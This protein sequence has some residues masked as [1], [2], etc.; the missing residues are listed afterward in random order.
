M[1]LKRAV[2]FAIHCNTPGS[3]PK[4]L[5]LPAASQS[6]A[7]D[8][9]LPSR[10]KR[11]WYSGDI[12]VDQPPAK[13]QR[14]S[15]VHQLE[16]FGAANHSIS[17]THLANGTRGKIARPEPGSI[18][19]KDTTLPLATALA[20]ASFEEAEATLKEC[21]DARTFWSMPDL[22]VELTKEMLSM[23]RTPG[24]YSLYYCFIRTGNSLHARVSQAFACVVLYKLCCESYSCSS[25]VGKLQQANVKVPRKKIAPKSKHA[26]RRRYSL[27]S[28]VK[29]C[30]T[31]GKIYCKL[32]NEFGGYGIV[33]LLP[34][35]DD[36]M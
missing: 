22:N 19:C 23:S 12:Q 30:M 28:Y 14:P 11:Q 36:A 3:D 16:A 5:E 15:S 17:N 31:L 27:Y 10:K 33:C 2:P 21:E 18:L 35:I 34:V 32:A 6:A 9:T 1:V 29:S 26:P 20:T 24:F 13:F 8:L 25:I 7:T 4:R